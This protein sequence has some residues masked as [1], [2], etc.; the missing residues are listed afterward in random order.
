M[1]HSHP[2]YIN[3]YKNGYSVQRARALDAFRTKFADS[4]SVLRQ[5]SLDLW[6]KNAAR[7]TTEARTYAASCHFFTH[8][9]FPTEIRLKTGYATFPFSQLFRSTPGAPTLGRNAYGSYDLGE[10]L[11][12]LPRKNAD[13][14][15]HRA[16]SAHVRR[17]PG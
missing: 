9:V 3:G 10:S 7:R 16:P 11:P 13:V 14:M 8:P 12:R 17:R 1:K 6:R 15:R 2:K 5:S 4:K